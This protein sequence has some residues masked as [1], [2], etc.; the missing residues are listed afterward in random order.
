MLV[1]KN[2]LMYRMLG[3]NQS[4]KFKNKRTG[5]LYGFIQLF[6]K[7]VNV[8]LPSS[9]VVCDDYPPYKKLEIF[10]EFKSDR[11]DNPSPEFHEYIRESHDYVRHFLSMINIPCLSIKGLEADDLIAFIIQN[12]GYKYDYNIICSN[13]DDLFQLLSENVSLQRSK[14]VYTLQDF[15]KEYELEPF[16]WS[17]VLTLKGSHNGLKP[18]EKGMGPVHSL[19]IVK[20]VGKW[21]EFRNNNMDLYLKRLSIVQYPYNPDGKSYLEYCNLLEKE[22]FK[23]KRFDM[24]DV[25]NTLIF[26]YGIRIQPHMEEALQIILEGVR[27]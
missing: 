18:I 9:I 11:K 17:N 7:Y 20:D 26:D 27:E 25:I 2:N 3:I 21:V 14:D 22:N 5:G 4:M 16:H 6:S 19:E 13:D 12:I 1:D 23:F 8:H 24:R 15:R 10:P